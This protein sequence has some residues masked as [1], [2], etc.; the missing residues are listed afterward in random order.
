[1]LEIINKSLLHQIN[2]RE[3][4]ENQLKE[5]ISTIS[6]E[7][8]TPIS[9]LIM[10]IEYINKYK[11]KLTPEVEETL[12]N[13]LTRNISILN[14]LIEDILTLSRFEENEI[15]LNL[16]TCHPRKIIND[17]FLLMEPRLKANEIELIV[18]ID[19]DI[20]LVGDKQRMNQ[21]FRIFIDNSIKYSSKNSTI[22]IKAENNYNGKHNPNGDK[23]ILFQII[24]YGR[25]IPKEDI[26]KLFQRFFR[27][28]D[29]KDIP[30]TGLGLSIARELIK[31]H[32][33]EVFVE[34]EIGKGT[35]FSIFIPKKDNYK[36][37]KN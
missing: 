33:G 12:I 22:K 36:L 11:H 32:D 14:E 37:I 29:V 3:Y 27:S 9:V 7:L 34:S 13:G 17:V 2:E 25:G 18:E 19:D 23:G 4:A 21:I 28:I 24:D 8:R 35:I 31:L 15:K 10:S 5:F 16:E 26:P 30:G 20:V 1:D 6:H